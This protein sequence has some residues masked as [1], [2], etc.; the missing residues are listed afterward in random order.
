MR[1]FYCGRKPGAH[2]GNPCK[3]NV[4][5]QRCPS[6]AGG[7][8][9]ERSRPF[10]PQHHRTTSAIVH[11]ICKTVQGVQHTN[12]SEWRRLHLCIRSFNQS[13]IHPRSVTSSLTSSVGQG[14]TESKH[15]PSDMLFKVEGKRTEPD[16]E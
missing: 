12:L 5:A 10:R 2:R 4:Y 3:Y 7:S 13:L 9:S 16:T 11:L 6:R 15:S 8:N 1:V 14:S